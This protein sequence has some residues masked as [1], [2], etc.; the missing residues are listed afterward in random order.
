MG[1]VYEFWLFYSIMKSFTEK[2]YAKL[3]KVPRGRVTTY[4]MIAESLG[5][6]TYRAVGTAM[7]KNPYAPEVPCHRVVNSDGRIGG[8]ASGRE[9][10]IKILKK[11]GVEVEGGKIK[12]FKK[13]FFEL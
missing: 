9:N 1:K 10:K 3:R 12:D 13:R 7:N 6:K 8:F 4:G 5:T 2:C 11:E